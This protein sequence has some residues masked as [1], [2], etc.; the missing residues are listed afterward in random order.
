M[1]ARAERL[2]DDPQ[3]GRAG[4][5]VD[6][7]A[8]VVWRGDAPEA[9][10]QVDERR[11][12][13]FPVPPERAVRGPRDDD[14]ARARPRWDVPA[15]RGDQIDDLVARD[16]VVARAREAI[17]GDLGHAPRAAEELESTR[18]REHV[19]DQRRETRVVGE[20]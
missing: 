16:E 1:R 2:A 13:F 8:V 10:A 7:V 12:H 18:A 14:V 11:W 9:V 6:D 19:H 17:G 3:A 20:E 4:A 5:E 15:V